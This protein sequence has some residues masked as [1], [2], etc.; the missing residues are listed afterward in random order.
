MVSTIAR[1]TIERGGYAAS[2][3]HAG[4]RHLA[5]TSRTT[6]T[7][8]ATS[9]S[10]RDGYLYIGFGDGG[11]GGDPDSTGSGHDRLARLD[12]LRSMSTVRS[13]V[14]NSARQSV[15]GP[16]CVLRGSHGLVQQLSRDLRLGIPQPMALELRF[17]R[18]AI[19]GPAT[20]DK[21]RVEEIDRVERGGNYGWDCREGMAAYTGPPGSAAAVCSTIPAAS[22][23]NPV[24]QYGRSLGFSVTG[25]FVYRGTALARARGA[26]SVRRL[27]Q[28]PNLAARRRAA[29]RSRRK[30][31]STRSLSIASFGQGNDGELY[32]V[33]I[34]GG[35]VA[36]DRRRR[37]RRAGRSAG[38]DAA[39]GHGLRE[40]RESEPAGHGP[41]SVRRLPRRSGRTARRRSAGSRSRTARRS[42]WAPTATSRSRT[43]RC[44]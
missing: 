39:I 16:A 27:R 15:R 38:A 4:Q 33:D 19:F 43:A 41:D 12:F 14:C 24:H 7:T 35:G 20:W 34:A 2:T 3:R 18:P 44:S 9:R 13:T 10:A 31:C 22:L 5:S 17:W 29:A 1:F 28:R 40:R 25:G 37:R 26:L 21:A 32:V 30:S 36:Q 6:I 42:A 23:I 11:G 8:A